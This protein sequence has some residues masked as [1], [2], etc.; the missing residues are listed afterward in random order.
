MKFKSASPPKYF[1]ELLLKE[2]L[3]NMTCKIGTEASN[4]KRFMIYMKSNKLDKVS[5]SKDVI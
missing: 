3:M 1:L 5:R 4:I 2:L